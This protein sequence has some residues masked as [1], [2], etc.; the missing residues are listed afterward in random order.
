MLSLMLILML[1]MI[2]KI[3][4][5]SD[6][7]YESD[8][9][10]TDEMEELITKFVQKDDND[11]EDGDSEEIEEY[12]VQVILPGGSTTRSGRYVKAKDLRD[13]AYYH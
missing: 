2:I 11:V 13:F 9:D 3:I 1:M 6:C 7:D 5:E 12:V 8:R 10:E 4:N